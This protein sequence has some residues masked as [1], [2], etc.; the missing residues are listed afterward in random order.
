MLRPVRQ[1]VVSVALAGALAGMTPA[2]PA[3]ADPP[4]KQNPSGTNE[5]SANYVPPAAAPAADPQDLAAAGS[6]ATESPADA[7]D[8]ASA[9]GVEG[10]PTPGPPGEPAEADATIEG[11]AADSQATDAKTTDPKSTGISESDADL[12]VIELPAPAVS[13]SPR[14]SRTPS[15]DS[16]TPQ[17][18]FTLPPGFAATELHVFEDHEPEPES[19]LA[20]LLARTGGPWIAF[21]VVGSLAAGAGGLLLRRRP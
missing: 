1:L 20:G 8:S 9:A 4:H 11:I 5:N 16:P 14:T 17:P 19:G 7:P 15:P 21:G 6:S 12:P 18:T 2:A 13:S 3:L 10:A